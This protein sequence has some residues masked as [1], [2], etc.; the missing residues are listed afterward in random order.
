MSG[1]ALRQNGCGSTY[2]ESSTFRFGNAEPV[3]GRTAIEGMLADFYTHITAMEH[4]NTG[5]WLGDNSA[6]FEAEVT[7][8]RRD[9]TR[10]TI[11]SSS[12]LR[13]RG[14][15]IHDFRMIMDA[16]PILA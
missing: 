1:K 2:T 3:R 16:A 6:V 12:I 4:R 8:Q 13:L 14:A 7:F 5:L 11:P 9:D 10:L 15:V